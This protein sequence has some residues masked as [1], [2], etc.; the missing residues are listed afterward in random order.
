MRNHI[1]SSGFPNIPA[2]SSA[3]AVDPQ[4]T[5]SSD[6]DTLLLVMWR[7]YKIIIGCTIL[8]VAAGFL[9]LAKAVP[10]F[11]STARIYVEQSGPKIMGE[12]EEG[13]MTGNKNYL[14]T[15][16]ELLKSSPILLEALKKCDA[17]RMPTFAHADN[18]LSFLQHEISANVGRKDDII[19]VSFKSPYPLEAAHVVNTV[20]DS[21]VT[22]HAERKRST[23]SEVL[24]IL[25]KEMVTR[26]HELSGNLRAMVDFKESNVEMGLQTEQGHITLDRLSQ[27]SQALTQA[28]LVTL[29]AKSYYEA[30]R[31]IEDDPDK[32]RQFVLAQQT[33][34]PSQVPNSEKDGLKA[35]LKRRLN[36]RSD[37]LRQLTAQHPAVKA[38]DIEIEELEQQII[39]IE[40]ASI[41]SQLAA[42]EQQYLI[43][44][45]S[46]RQLAAH[47]AEQRELALKLNR[48]VSQYTLLQSEWE[49]SQKTCEIL[50]DRIKEL[51]V[52]EDA[53]VLNITILEVARPA[54]EPSEPQKSRVMA[55]TLL[56]G[57]VLG[58]GMALLKNMMDHRIR[59]ADEVAT[60]LHA[61]LLGTVPAMPKRN[62]V[63]QRGQKILR[64][65]HSQT[66]EAFR[67]I[68]TA[69]FF[70]VPQDQGRILHVTS[71]G[72]GEGKSTFVS[73]LAIAMAQSDQRT[74]IIDA[75][76]RRPTQHV[77]FGVN[78]E[79]GLTAVLAGLQDIKQAILQT[80]VDGLY[81]LPGGPSVPDPSEMLGRKAF[82]T[83][84]AQLAEEYDR[85][86]VDSP[87]VVPVADGSI[88]ST[89]CDA[90]VLV[91]RAR[92]TS[93]K[94]LLQAASILL[95][96][97]A[98]L[99]GTVFN[100]V[101][102]H[103]GRYGYYEYGHG[104]GKADERDSKYHGRSKRKPKL[105]TAIDSARTHAVHKRETA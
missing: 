27:L 57:L 32:L 60:L 59:S 21:Y 69:L 25:Q 87:P 12:L 47:V 63:S 4:T 35:E 104:G 7:N 76:L 82:K 51:N 36:C 56:L 84:L 80:E 37:R 1:I 2:E 70:S 83:L 41:Q 42:L 53:G 23:A 103:R 50:N 66:A 89:R 10:I 93:R 77:I 97:R 67:T 8:T 46:E 98:S 18:P 5:Q 33:S 64:E 96:V 13:F 90:T 40:K 31:Q 48:Q 99:I 92:Q 54:D 38:L 85:I 94:A 81:L 78:K 49:Q 88:L 86:L 30:S 102:Q 34:T 62:S 17:G 105:V 20:I 58:I 16:A 91:S 28:Q 15:Q 52:T 100:D 61:P 26:R 3:S 55:Q 72:P 45:E 101:K 65:A 71:A 74:L 75:D 24:K 11:A 43:A 14:H 29:E 95:S 68:R 79:A 73:N 6:P 9:Y 22:F 44:Q 39:Q 19:A